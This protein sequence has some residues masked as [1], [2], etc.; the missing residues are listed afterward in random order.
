MRTWTS[1]GAQNAVS[2]SL[3]SSFSRYVEAIL[4]SQ[5]FCFPSGMPFYSSFRYQFH[6]HHLQEVL[7][8]F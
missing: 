6:C 4:F 1:L 7:L 5:V 3:L 8:D 2:M